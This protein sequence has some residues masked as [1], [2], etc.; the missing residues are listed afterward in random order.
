M[1]SPS[2]MHWGCSP[3][4]LVELDAKLIEWSKTEIPIKR[5]IWKI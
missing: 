1:L 3:K 4:E 5:I 2:G